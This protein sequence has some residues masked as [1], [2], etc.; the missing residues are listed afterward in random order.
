MYENALGRDAHLT[1]M[2]VAAL[3][4]WLDHLVEVGTAVDNG[5]GGPAMLQSAARAG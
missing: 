4:H 2:I 3:D 5:R 1:G